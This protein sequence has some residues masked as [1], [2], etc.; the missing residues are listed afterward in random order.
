MQLL[1]LSAG[2]TLDSLE[3][4][5]RFSSEE[6]IGIGAAEGANHSSILNAKR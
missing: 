1:K 2:G 6:A 5:H 4:A 3:P